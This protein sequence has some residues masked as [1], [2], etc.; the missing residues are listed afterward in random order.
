[1]RPRRPEDPE[2]LQSQHLAD[3]NLYATRED[4][5]R[6]YGDR[7]VGGVIA[8]IGTAEGSFSRFLIDTCR[9]KVFHAYDL[10]NMNTW[11]T[12]WGRPVEE[13]LEGKQHIEF[14]QDRF[15]EEIDRGVVTAFQGDGAENL[16]LQPPN[17]YDLIYIDAEHSRPS[18]ERDAQEAIR[19]LK[20]GG[21]L[22][23]ND[24]TMFDYINQQ[25]YGIVFVVNDLCVNRGWQITKF[26]LHARMYCD[27][28]I[29]RSSPRSVGSQP[30]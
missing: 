5:I 11:G 13:V 1:M 21:V 9:P 6:S 18:V 16:A 19:R 30:A 8:E 17:T 26:A 2:E 25:E 3:A 7:F 27:V 14:F 24:Y 20:P 15:K 23:F 22:I 4:M 10:F 28:A 29:E 12:A